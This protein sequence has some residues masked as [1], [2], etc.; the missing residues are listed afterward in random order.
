MKYDYYTPGYHV[1][2]RG[3]LTRDNYYTDFETALKA[4][5]N[6]CKRGNAEVN[7]IHRPEYSNGYRNMKDIMNDFVFF[8]EDD[9]LDRI[10]YP[11]SSYRNI[12]R[13]GKKRK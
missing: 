5:D 6:A 3:R 8:S 11:K 4:Y 1:I 10:N 13:Q 7:L 9:P 12:A 2:T